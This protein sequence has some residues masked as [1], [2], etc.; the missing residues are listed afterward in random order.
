MM[1]LL[2]INGN[3]VRYSLSLAFGLSLTTCSLQAATTNFYHMNRTYTPVAYTAGVTT[4]YSLMVGLSN[5]TGIVKSGT[6]VVMDTN[7]SYAVEYESLALGYASPEV[8]WYAVTTNYSSNTHIHSN[9]V[10][11]NTGWVKGTHPAYGTWGGYLWFL[12][13]HATFKTSPTNFWV[14]PYGVTNLIAKVFVGTVGD[15]S[16]ATNVVDVGPTNLVAMTNYLGSGGNTDII[17]RADFDSYYQLVV[18]KLDVTNIKFNWDTSSSASDAINIR[19]DYNTPYDI[20]AGEWVKGGAN[21]PVCYTT[22]KA[23]MIQARFTVQPTNIVNADVWAVSIG[24]G[25][26]LGNVIKTNVTFSGGVSVPEYIT[27]QVSG[28]TTNCIRK[29]TSDLWQWKMGNVNGINTPATDFATS[30]VHTVYTIL[31]E[32][33]APWDNS[34]GSQKNAWVKALDFGIGNASCNGDSRASNAL[35]HITQFLHTGHGLTYDIN[36]G[37]NA[38]SSD[39][40]GGTFQLTEYIDKTGGNN[41]SPS[42]AGN[43]VNCYDQAGGVFTLGHLFGVPV[44]Y[45]FMQPF[46]YINTVNL[47]GEGNCN[48]PFY[49]LSTSGLK[50]AGTNDVSP[51]RKGFGN[52]AFNAYD[53]FIF[54]ACAGPSIGTKTAA[55]YVSDTV[56]ESTPAEAAAAGTVANISLGAITDIQ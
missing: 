40:L 13:N 52:H 32:P 49:P 30:G 54:D 26:S 7:A 35:A 50:I 36:G 12:E 23:V 24:T 20:S 3:F 44:S 4:V 27:F 15:Y 31:G 9:V 11:D 51:V 10:Y 39:Y 53:G 6:N 55:Q 47:I 37:E 21:I 46:G 45:M 8:A 14:S 48:N 19:Q 18:P 34:A 28:R 25:S 38:Y 33:V 43:I 16:P 1:A 17:C 56:D 5:I 42:R 22:N 2:R 41:V 29:S